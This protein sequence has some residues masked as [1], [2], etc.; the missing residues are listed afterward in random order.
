MRR[1]NL[2]CPHNVIVLY[3][4]TPI[5]D[6]DY[7]ELI[8]QYKESQA[9]RKGKYSK[10]ASGSSSNATPFFFSKMCMLNF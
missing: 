10:K 8:A 4:I 7:K 2:V 3:T 6:T 9:A 1:R 5:V